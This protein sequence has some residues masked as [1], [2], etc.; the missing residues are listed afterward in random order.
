[1]PFERHHPNEIIR[2]DT[3]WAVIVS[4]A[5]VVNRHTKPDG[6]CVKLTDHVYGVQAVVYFYRP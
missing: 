1:M 2:F 3:G 4:L 5:L 6:P